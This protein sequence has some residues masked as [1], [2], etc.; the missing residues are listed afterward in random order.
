MKAGDPFSA[1]AQGKLSLTISITANIYSAAIVHQALL[2]SL[3]GS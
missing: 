2:Y 1:S 3:S